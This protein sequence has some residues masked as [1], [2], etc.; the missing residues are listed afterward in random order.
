MEDSL[1][2]V[3][4]DVVVLVVVLEGDMD[5]DADADALEMEPARDELTDDDEVRRGRGRDV[6]VVEL[7]MRTDGPS[8]DVQSVGPRIGG[9][10]TTFLLADRCTALRCTTLLLAAGGEY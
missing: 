7:A 10:R 3:C 6:D 5:V 2:G 8:N 9:M 4:D 1:R